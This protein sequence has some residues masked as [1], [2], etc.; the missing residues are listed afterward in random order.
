[1]S[2]GQSATAYHPSSASP[3]PVGY[4]TQDIPQYPHNSSMVET[5]SKGDGFWKGCWSL[6][7]W[8]MSAWTREGLPAE[9]T[10][11]LKSAKALQK[12]NQVINGVMNAY[13]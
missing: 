6:P 7:G 2:S 4:P 9:R 12:S 11:K 10:L 5:K 3:P 8:Y 1:M 13:L